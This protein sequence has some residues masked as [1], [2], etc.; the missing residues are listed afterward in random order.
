MW[1]ID[2]MDGTGKS[3]LANALQAGLGGNKKSKVRHSPKPKPKDKRKIVGFYLQGA[4]DVVKK[5]LILDR[6]WPSHL[7]YEQFFSKRQWIR[8]EEMFIMEG[9]GLQYDLAHVHCKAKLGTVVG[10]IQ[11]DQDL[12]LTPQERQNQ[13]DN[14]EE[15]LAR[16]A[17]LYEHLAA[18]GRRRVEVYNTG[19]TTPEQMVNALLLAS[20]TDMLH[21]EKNLRLRQLH[22][23]GWGSPSASILVIGNR[24]SGT[25]AQ[26]GEDRMLISPR[27]DMERLAFTTTRGTG[28]DHHL[29]RLLLFAGLQPMDCYF[30]NAWQAKQPSVPL[31][32]S[33]IVRQVS[34]MCIL[35]VGKRAMKWADQFG[36]EI[37]QPKSVIALPD[38][39]ELAKMDI[40]VFSRLAST[41][42]KT[43]ENETGLL[44]RHARTFLEGL[45][46]ANYYQS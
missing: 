14:A 9:I 13:I 19:E 6:W 24:T 26:S 10:R 3:T 20:K 21:K 18:D 39:E 41:L 35:L 1:L 33:E 16:Y 43:I 32:T 34:P 37:T 25:N 38:V 44:S 15:L 17:R 29:I 45:Y 8:R 30:H 31:L 2:G 40:V 5:H 7:I 23:A 42:R 22:S 28:N 4:E 12:N 27:K 46:N 11:S 36:K